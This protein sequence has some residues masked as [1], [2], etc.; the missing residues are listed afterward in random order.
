MNIKG[1]NIFFFIFV[2]LKDMEILGPCEYL[3]T[4]DPDYY[5]FFCLKFHSYSFSNRTK[6]LVGHRIDASRAEAC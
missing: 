4:T 1:L 2:D 6:C 3:R 5:L